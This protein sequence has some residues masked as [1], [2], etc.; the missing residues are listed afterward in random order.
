MAL[1]PRPP[2][3]PVNLSATAE[4]LRAA[5]PP[6]PAGAFGSDVTRIFMQAS[7]GNVQWAEAAA[8]PSATGA[9]H[10]LP[11]GAGLILDIF[12][13]GDVRPWVRAASAGATLIV[14]AA[15]RFG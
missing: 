11:D 7:G 8:A 9:W 5:L 12:A 10:A 2:T 13:R 15:Y 14:T 3:F 1:N 4:D 6:L